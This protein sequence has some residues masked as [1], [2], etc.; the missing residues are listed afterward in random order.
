MTAGMTTDRQPCQLGPGLEDGVLLRA[1]S[2]LSQDPEMERIVLFGSRARGD[3]RQG[4]DF[5]LLLLL[6]GTLTP[7]REKLWRRRVRAL[8]LPLLPVD[9]DLLIS[10]TATAAHW[11]GSR[12]HVLGHIHREGVPLHVS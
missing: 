2:S 3:A 10:D 7:E 11:A 5:D 6:R 8:L 9:L 4:S 12:W 1:L